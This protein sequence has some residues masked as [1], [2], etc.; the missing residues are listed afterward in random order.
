MVFRLIESKSEADLHPVRQAFTD[1][2]LR[3]RAKTG[4]PDRIRA[5]FHSDAAQY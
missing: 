3:I 2:A 5:Q 4:V 1:L